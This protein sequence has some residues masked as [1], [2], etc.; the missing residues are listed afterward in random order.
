MTHPNL[1][2]STLLLLIAVIVI[3]R[4]LSSALRHIGQP[5]VIGEI[6]AGIL[7]GP[8][9]LAWL[10]PAASELL[11]PNGIASHLGVIAQLG[12][13]LYMFQLGLELNHTHLNGRAARVLTISLAGMALP[14]VLGAALGVSIF[15]EYAGTQRNFLGFVLFVAIALSVTALPVLARIL[16]DHALQ[17]TVL[18]GT[19]LACAAVA[20]VTAWCLL[21]AVVAI[22]QARPQDAIW[23]AV[24]ALAF[25]VIALCFVRPLLLKV[26][27]RDWH[28]GMVAILVVG[29]LTAALITEMIGLHL[30][31]GAFV[32]GALIPHD[33][34]LA[35]EF[36]E[37]FHDVTTSVL[38]PAF[39]AVT[40]LR[41]QLQLLNSWQD[42]ALCGGIILLAT[43]GKVA[44]TTLA[45]R[46]MKMPWREASAM[47]ALMNTRG[48]V[49]LIVLNIG[50][51][52]GVISPRLFAMLVIMALA[53]TL[54]TA[55]AL[56]ALGF[57]SRAKQRLGANQ[58]A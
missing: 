12:V 5:P 38:L 57:P 1:A 42:W 27:R 17:S 32:L 30:V 4:L 9:C 26:A 23:S 15:S 33:S 58:L 14:F 48:L 36:D 11:L 49:E 54:M 35:R 8:S 37:R 50:L 22:T 46:G 39:F 13:V 7:L 47:G 28:P 2:T 24:Y 29:V 41:L 34:A 43:F 31:F 20:D 55:P 53:T 44:A 51:E 40:G 16:Q 56:H 3:G 18:G 10:W 45:A 52:L 19:A 25:V 6:L 21:S